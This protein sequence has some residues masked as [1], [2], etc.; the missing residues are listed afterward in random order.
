MGVTPIWPF[1]LTTN[2]LISTTLAN[3]TPHLYGNIGGIQT[4]KKISITQAMGTWITSELSAINMS[5]TL[6]TTLVQQ[7]AKSL[8]VIKK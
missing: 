1:T 8:K 7:I 6:N 5:P 3:T 4:T 2:M